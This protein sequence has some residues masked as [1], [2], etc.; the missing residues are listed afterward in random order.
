MIEELNDINFNIVHVFN[1]EKFVDNAIGLF[2]DV[3]PEKSMYYVLQFSKEPFRFVNSSKAKSLLITKKGEEKKVVDLI[4]KNKI[5]VV[6]LHALDDCKQSIVN[7]LGEDVIKVWLIWG[8][9]LYWNW[10]ILKI[11]MFESETFSYLYNGNKNS[12][13]RK[14]IFNNFSLWLFTNYRNKKI[15]LPKFLAKRLENNYL[16]DFYKTVQKIHIVAPIVPTEY[17]IVKS[18]NP[19]LVYAP[20]NYGNIEDL[21]IDDNDNNVEKSRSILIGNSASPTNNHVDAFKRI[22]KIRR[23]GQKVIVPLSYG[24]KKEYIQFVIE[25]GK[26][27]FGD[28]FKPIIDFLPLN[29]YN[30][31]ISGCEYAVFNHIR[32]QAVGN[33]VTMGYF[34]TKIFLNGKSPVYKYFKKR[35]I[36]VFSIEEINNKSLSS[37]MNKKEIEVNRALLYKLYSRNAVKIKVSEFIQIVDKKLNKA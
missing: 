25:K 34:G 31:L 24:G 27:Y 2:E 11:N 1:D 21:L 37:R 23:G 28:D 36:H 32:Q 29:L 35:G 30:Q 16:T 15:S 12:V 3:Y 19:N 8:A 6:F 33:I 26:R 20:F 4:N 9:D 14:L 10:K 18:I 22:Y 17:K 7:Q 5:K 13:K